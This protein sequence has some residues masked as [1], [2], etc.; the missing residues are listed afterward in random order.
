M[1]PQNILSLLKIGVTILFYF[2]L[3][4]TAAITINFIIKLGSGGHDRYFEIQHGDYKNMFID[5]SDNN[6]MPDFRYSADQL[7][8]YRPENYLYSVAVASNSPLGYYTMTATLVFLSLGL[9]VLWN[10]KKI[11]TDVKLNNPF[12][13]PVI[14]RLNLL[15]AVFI[16]SDIL[17]IIHYF[18][19]DLLITHSLHTP[20][21]KLM[22]ESGNGILIGLI[23][24]II[25]VIYKRGLEA[26]HENSLTV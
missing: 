22:T 24:I 5:L 20:R 15:A 25:A 21:L 1:K 2:L 9:I 3:L 17:G 23:I 10:F 26:Y 11:F 8:R 18:T 16:A 13:Q 6:K 7:V 19:L 4:I 14:K 12:K